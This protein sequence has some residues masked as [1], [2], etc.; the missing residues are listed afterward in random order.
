[1][2]RQHKHRHPVKRRVGLARRLSPLLRRVSRSSSTARM[3][4][5][6]LRPPNSE[7]PK[8]SPSQPFLL[9]LPILTPPHPLLYFAKCPSHGSLS[10]CVV[11]LPSLSP[12]P[13]P[14]SFSCVYVCLSVRVFG[15]SLSRVIFSLPAPSHFCCPMYMGRP[16]P[17]PARHHKAPSG[18]GGGAQKLKTC[19]RPPPL[20]GQGKFQ[21]RINWLIAH[22]LATDYHIP[23]LPAHTHPPM[24]FPGVCDVCFLSRSSRRS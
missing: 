17:T 19:M 20:F 7:T 16:Q 4:V 1:M 10:C 21:W 9:R 15:V 5:S 11:C 23:R 6:S 3:R 14:P 24:T 22:S 18:G 8:P 2:S 12:L 13:P